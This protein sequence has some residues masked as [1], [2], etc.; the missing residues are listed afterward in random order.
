MR[1]VTH[2]C[3]TFGVKT[4]VKSEMRAKSLG[5]SNV[6]M[7][8][9]ECTEVTHEC[10]LV[11]PREIRAGAWKSREILESTRKFPNFLWPRGAAAWRQ[12]RSTRRIP[13]GCTACGKIEN[14]T[15]FRVEWKSGKT[16]NGERRW[17]FADPICRKRFSCR[18]RT[19]SAYG[20]AVRRTRSRRSSGVTT[21]DLARGLLRPGKLIY[22]NSCPQVRGGNG[23]ASRGVRMA[24]VVVGADERDSERVG[25]SVRLVQDFGRPS[26][27]PVTLDLSAPSRRAAG[28]RRRPQARSR[29]PARQWEQE[30]GAAHAGAL[31][32]SA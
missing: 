24:L 20:V 3:V 2:I 25:G 1:H 15:I 19:R 10:A 23:A 21:F 14:K 13:L 30:T 29:P 27:S 4:A 12:A 7:E 5:A 26:H 11:G 22:V 32:S 8:R 9:T 16:H 31:K 17:A 6:Y 18:E 28:R